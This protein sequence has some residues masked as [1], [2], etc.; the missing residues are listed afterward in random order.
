MNFHQKKHKSG[1]NKKAQTKRSL[2]KEEIVII[3]EVK[4]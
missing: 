3:S 1:L 4:T 2:S